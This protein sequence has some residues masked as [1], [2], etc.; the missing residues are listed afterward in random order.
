MVETYALSAAQKAGGVIS[1]QLICL[2]KDKLPTRLRL[3]VYFDTASGKE[4]H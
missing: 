2:D 4:Y 3:V 1:D